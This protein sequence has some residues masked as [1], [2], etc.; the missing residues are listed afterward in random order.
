MSL[1]RPRNLLCTK[2]DLGLTYFICRT[3]KLRKTLQIQLQC[4]VQ[5]G[6]WL[7]KWEKRL[8]IVGS[9]RWLLL[10]AKKIVARIV[11]YH[12]HATSNLATVFKKPE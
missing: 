9:Y 12:E 8:D 2:V 7:Q 4:V 5:I 3:A 1:I 6:S 10:I 11:G